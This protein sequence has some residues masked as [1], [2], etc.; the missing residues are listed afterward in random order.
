MLRPWPRQQ[1]PCPSSAAFSSGN[2]WSV[3]VMDEFRGVM[4]SLA[5]IGVP[6]SAGAHAPGQERAPEAFVAQGSWASSPTMASSSTIEVTSPRS[7]GRPTS[8]I[9]AHSMQI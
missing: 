5:M 8:A 2:G 1:G 9:H 6:S 7:V 4:R 3:A